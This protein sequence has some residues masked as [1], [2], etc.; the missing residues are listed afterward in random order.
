MSDAMRKQKADAKLA[1]D[2]RLAAKLRAMTPE[3]RAAHDA[4]VADAARRESRK[5]RM[6]QSQLVRDRARPGEGAE[7]ASWP[8]RST[9]RPSPRP[10]RPSPSFL[11][12][13]GRLRRG[14]QE[15]PRQGDGAQPR[16]RRR[17]RRWRWRRRCRR[18]MT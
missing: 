6:L 16:R 14:R 13:A 17:R 9:A 3:E 2:D 1:E 12:R 10:P 4:E 7:E 11:S 15:E 8:L 5:N 18:K